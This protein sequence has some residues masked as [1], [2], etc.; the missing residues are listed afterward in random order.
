MLFVIVPLHKSSF[1]I[2]TKGSDVFSTQ[3][4]ITTTLLLLGKVVVDQLANSYFPTA[5]NVVFA[6]VSSA[7]RF[8]ESYN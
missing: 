7:D 8:L 3:N 1:R 4:I 5:I 2:Y 6:F